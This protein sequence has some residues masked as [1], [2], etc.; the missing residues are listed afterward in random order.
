MKKH[1][2]YT[3][4]LF[5]LCVITSCSKDFL[6][7]LP[8][9]TRTTSNVYKTS[10][11]FYNAVIGTYSTFKH[12][13]LYGNAGSASALLNLGETVSD[14]VDFGAT[15]AVSNVSTFELEDFNF[16]LSNTFF[17]SAWT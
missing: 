11:D 3:G 13:G 1:F 5:S 15:R 14:N 7:Q 6:E 16:S 8:E 17:S 10:G 9:T 4:L 2:I 12:N